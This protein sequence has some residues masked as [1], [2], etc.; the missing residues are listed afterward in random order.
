MIENAYPEHFITKPLPPDF[1]PNPI[2]LF[3]GPKHEKRWQEMSKKE[4]KDSHDWKNLKK[5]YD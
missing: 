4:R 3:R 2:W 1:K 5:R